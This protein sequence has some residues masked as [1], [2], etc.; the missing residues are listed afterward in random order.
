M[1]QEPLP[2]CLFCGEH[3]GYTWRLTDAVLHQA[4]HTTEGLILVCR[5]GYTAPASAMEEHI[6]DPMHVAELRLIL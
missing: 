4:V 5:C 3:H 6:S 1:M 2:P